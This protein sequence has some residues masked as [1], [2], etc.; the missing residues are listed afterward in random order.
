MPPW[1]QSLL[2][3]LI[4]LTMIV[5][6]LGL[7][8]PIF[9]GN[10]VMWIASLAYGLIFGFGKLGTAMFAL[11]TVLMLIA[12]SADNVLMGAKA[13]QQGA[14]WSSILAAVAS[15]VIFTLI[16]PPVGGFVAAPLV[17]YL[18]ELRRLRDSREAWGIVKALLV[19]LGLSFVVRFGLGLVMF[20]LW[21]IWA[22]T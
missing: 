17:L 18:L 14:A 11:I 15:V 19:G 2:G 10:V 21:G 8:V 5:G 9:P 6:Q 3:F 16:F 1:L 13:R 20:I 12:V 22:F 4:L 7:I